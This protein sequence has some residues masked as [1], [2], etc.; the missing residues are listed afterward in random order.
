M[1]SAHFDGKQSRDP[2]DL[3]STCHPSPSHTTSA[4]RSREV[5][6]LLLDLDSY[7]G[8]NP[9]GMFFLEEDSCSRPSSRCGISAALSFR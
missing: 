3:P 6:R 2:V 8:T 5:I 7:S 4:F 1:F 9:L